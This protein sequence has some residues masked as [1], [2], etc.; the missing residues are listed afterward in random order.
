[1]TTADYPARLGGQGQRRCLTCG[2][3]VA[4]LGLLFCPSCDAT[5]S[6][7]R[8]TP[9]VFPIGVGALRRS[10]AF[11][12]DAVLLL[13]VTTPLTT[14]LPAS[15]DAAAS[16]SLTA[17]LGFVAGT[18]CARMLSGRPC[19]RTSCRARRSCILKVRSYRRGRSMTMVKYGPRCCSPPA[20]V[21]AWRR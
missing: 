5:N 6:L 21:L 18:R 8:G 12:V 2:D 1:M 17:R 13:V 16:A 15:G 11:L 19:S 4:G 14:M 7:P 9:L 20:W 10:L 3:A